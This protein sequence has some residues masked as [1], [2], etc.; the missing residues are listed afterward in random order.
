MLVLIWIFKRDDVNL[1]AQIN[2]TKWN[3]E[4]GNNCIVVICIPWHYSS[5]LFYFTLL[6]KIRGKLKWKKSLKFQLLAK[7]FKTPPP[8]SKKG[9]TNK[10]IGILF[11][12]VIIKFSFFKIS[13]PPP[14]FHQEAEPHRI[15][16]LRWPLSKW[17][18]KFFVCNW[19]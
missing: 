18:S 4:N 6:L 13:N 14:L 15:Y 17:V 11:Q 1:S 19:K 2:A 8:S 9:P 7:I 12:I 5:F 3:V 10:N 16:Q